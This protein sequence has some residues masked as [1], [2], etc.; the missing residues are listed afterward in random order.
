MLIVYLIIFFGIGYLFNE[1][2]HLFISDSDSDYEDF[3]FL[4]NSDSEISDLGMDTTYPKIYFS[5]VD[6]IYYYDKYNNKDDLWYSYD[7]YLKFQK[8]VYI[9]NSNK[10]K[11]L[12]IICNPKL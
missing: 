2:L 7:D 12:K 8:E 11:L 4:S 10:K 3:S 9:E 6:T 5:E 1:N